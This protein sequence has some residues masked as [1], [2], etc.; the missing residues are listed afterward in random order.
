MCVVD[1]HR[2]YRNRK[3][4]AQRD[5]DH[6]E[7]NLGSELLAIRKFSD[8]LCVGLT[9]KGTISG[10]SARQVQRTVVSRAGDK[11]DVPLQRITREGSATRN[12]TEKQTQK[13]NRSVGSAHKA[14]CFICRK[15]LKRNGTVEC[16]NAIWECKTCHMPLC[17]QSRI[18]AETGRTDTCVST[19]L[20]SADHIEGCNGMHP[21]NT[22]FPK[23][24]QVNINPR[25]SS[26]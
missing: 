20:Q 19:H 15:Y 26:R 5:D 21:S 24:Q 23:E 6:R 2:W 25:R 22:A 3:Y 11:P 1:M 13:E 8:R 4:D 18:D 9:K 14:T 10:R 12:P 16:R 17:K 7:Q